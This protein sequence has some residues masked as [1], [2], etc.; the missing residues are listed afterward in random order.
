MVKNLNAAER[1][2]TA[3]LFA[4]ERQAVNQLQE[5]PDFFAKLYSMPENG[6]FTF[7][8]QLFEK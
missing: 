5:K 8:F 4:Y 3:F 7:K 1:D 6:K 2:C